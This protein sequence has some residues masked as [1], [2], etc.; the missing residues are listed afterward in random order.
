MQQGPKLN[1]KYV[2]RVTN[3]RLH[4][5]YCQTFYGKLQKFDNLFLCKQLQPYECSSY[6]NKIQN[7]KLRNIFTKLRLNCNWLKAYSHSDK[8]DCDHY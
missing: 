1:P 5:Q 3:L 7:V 8:A 4:D 6:L 2:K